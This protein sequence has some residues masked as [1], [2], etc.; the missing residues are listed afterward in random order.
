MEKLTKSLEDYLK[1]IY[2]FERKNGFARIKEVGFFLNLKLPSVNKAIKELKKKKLLNHEKYGYIKLT[3]KGKEIAMDIFEIHNCLLNFFKMLGFNYKKA[4]K[5]ACYL[6]HIMERKD[7]LKIRK[8]V[9][10]LKKKI[11]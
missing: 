5:Y 1:A 8:S 10:L 4:D 3:E 6:E 2:F 9:N 11:R 7:L